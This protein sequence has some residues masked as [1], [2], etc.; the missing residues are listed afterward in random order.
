M[1]LNSDITT[2]A[3]T[4]GDLRSIAEIYNEGIADR[5]A[6]FEITPRQTPD[7]ERWLDSSYPVVVCLS[8]GKVV[9]FASSFPY[10]DRECYRGVAEFSVYV[11]RSMRGRGFGKPVM[12]KLIEEC[13]SSGIWKLVSRV[14]PENMASR[15][16][17]KSLGFREVGV[18]EKHGKLNGVWKDTVIVELIIETNIT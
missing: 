6:T 18:Y 16:L 10:S 1:D 12:Q 3:A 7:I 9:S 4:H 2:R 14:F 17:L 5:I 8:N 11:R 13:R 15:G